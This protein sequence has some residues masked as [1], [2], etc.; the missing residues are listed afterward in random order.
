MR[1]VL[2]AIC[3]ALAGAEAAQ[4]QGC[5]FAHEKPAGG[6]IG[7]APLALG[8]SVMLGAAPELAR[9]GFEV[10]ARCARNPKDGISI[11]RQ[12]R[13]RGTLPEIVVMALGTNIWVTKG[14][15]KQ[16]LRAI[17]RRRELMLV[18]PYRSWRPFHTAPMRRIARR[19]PRR[20]TLI[21]WS[22]RADRNRHWLYSDGTHLQGSGVDAYTRILRRAAWSRQRARIVRR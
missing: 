8:D 4:A 11:L 15:I 12:R 13:R 3:L 16:M 14:E 5:G 10:D 17:G 18:T 20:V 1:V 22:M 6:R 21:D 19:K 9:A 2:V 7:S